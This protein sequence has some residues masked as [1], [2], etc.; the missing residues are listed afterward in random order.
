MSAKRNIVILGFF[1]SQLAEEDEEHQQ[2][3]MGLADMPDSLAEDS[4][5]G[6]SGGKR[7]GKKGGRGKGKKRTTTE[8]P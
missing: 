2:E 8:S 5:E 4:E 1:D 7:K 6:G 3:V